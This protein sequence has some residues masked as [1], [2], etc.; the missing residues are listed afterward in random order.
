MTF[1]PT[2]GQAAALKMVDA[3]LAHDRPAFAV[4][5][6]YAGTGKTTMLKVV[7]ELHGAPLI[8][9]PTGKAAVRVAEA[10]GL[11]AMTIHRWVYKANEDPRTGDL[12]WARKPLDE[13]LEHVPMNRLVVV[14][15]ASMISDTIWQDIWMLAEKIG[16]KVLLV[17]DPFQ[18]AP[19]KPEDKSFAAL[20]L[21]TPF[22]AD[23]VEVVRQ[24]LDNPIVRASMLVRAGE[25]EAMEAVLAL[26]GVD[27]KN[28]V[29]KFLGLSPNRALIAWRNDTRQ[30][31]NYAVRDALGRPK[32]D[33]AP[34]EPLLVM[35]NNYDLDRFNGE[36]VDFGGWMTPPGD[37]IAVRNA[38]KNL[39]VMASYGLARIDGVVFPTL[40]SP[41]EVFSQV[42][43]MP[44]KTMAVYSR[45]YA[46]QSLGYT[47]H[48]PSFLSANFGYC[49][50]A[51]KA[52]G[53]EWKDVVV[54]IE[55]GMKWLDLEGR[56]WLYTAITR[57]RD[58][59]WV[60]FS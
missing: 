51:H 27:Y 12:G 37:Q 20:N 3:L 1:T 38:A 21:K 34:G 19:V 8:L 60:C 48:T 55:H 26:P 10:T 4:L 33:L 23:L 42:K 11:A 57:A 46:R 24:A 40:L 53:S 9:T 43:G 59:V 2:E 44:P 14:D 18:L 28:L 16:L 54:V 49:L 22:R 31:L 13:I 5:T 41:E 50:T 6:G 45:V 17:G 58:N 36:V 25:E 32:L 39:S 52:Q 29:P 47:Q 30:Q 7:A 35:F 56:R 15:E